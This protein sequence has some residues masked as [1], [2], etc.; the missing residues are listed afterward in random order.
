M[1]ARL[2]EADARAV[3]LLLDRA[4]SSAQGNGDGAMYAASHSGVS[5]EQVA[6]VERVLKLL[7][8]MPAA[9]PGQDLVRRTLERIGAH[10]DA[11]MRGPSPVLID[12]ARPHA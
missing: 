12:G 6:A 1:S 10:T 9:D 8:V 2:S 11:P 7:D 4:V 3:D 5:N